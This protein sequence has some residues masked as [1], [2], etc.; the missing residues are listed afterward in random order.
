MQLKGEWMMTDSALVNSKNQTFSVKEIPK[1]L[2]FGMPEADSSYWSMNIAQ[3]PQGPILRK[4]PFL[5]DFIGGKINA[6]LKYIFNPRKKAPYVGMHLIKQNLEKNIK[7][8]V[9]ITLIDYPTEKK[10]LRMVRKTNFILIGMAIGCE[11]KVHE[12]KA[13]AQKIKHYSKNTDVEIVFGSYGATT[14]KQLGILTAADGT[15][16]KDSPEEIKAKKELRKYPYTGEGVQS[17]RAFLLN[18]QDKLGLELHVLPDAPLVSYPVPDPDVPPDNPFLRWLSIKSGLFGTPLDMNKLA[19]SLG[20]VNACSFCNTAKN[21][22]SKTLLYKDAQEM[23]QAMKKQVDINKKR[24]NYVPE[25]LFFLMDENFMRPLA[26]TEELCKLV[27]NSGKNI[28]WGTFGDIKGLLEY[29]KKYKDFRG[30]VRGGMNSIWIGLESKADVFKKRGGA[31]IKEVE[32][33]IHELQ[34]LGILVFG[35]FIPGLGI[36][37]EGDTKI[38]KDEEELK[39]RIKEKNKNITE[40]EVCRMVDAVKVRRKNKGR[41]DLLNIQEDMQW[42]VKLNTA[43][44]QVMM[45][46]DTRLVNPQTKEPMLTLSDEDIFHTYRRDDHPHIS[47]KR[48]EEIDKK[49]REIFY[50]ENGP[51]SLRF[52]LTMWDG[53][54]ILKDSDIP[55]EIIAATYYYWVGKRYFQAISLSSLFFSQTLFEK[56]SGKFLNRLA[57][58]FD[59]FENFEP[60]EGA[61]SDKYQRVFDEHD[62]KVFKI[63]KWIAT[64]L[65]RNFVQKHLHKEDQMNQILPP[66]CSQAAPVEV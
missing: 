33:M 42:W 32:T 58:F 55:A 2:F 48:L 51:V 23:Y 18:N 29:K 27:E 4:L 60:P 43:A 41:Y 39:K 35:S 62:G 28:R 11:N 6:R 49:A 65:R 46:T 17:M 45:L 7:G 66:A 8:G 63:A 50:R 64:R 15:V 40:T 53:Y 14:G 3:A 19:V 47:G 54:K 59:E 16:L 37:T 61:L 57:R 31:S 21:F 22:G 26:N 1:M 30:L 5:P 36:H 25:T 38:I 24:K 56:C 34:N 20:C 44:N 52:V 12:A 13:L 9:D 10:I